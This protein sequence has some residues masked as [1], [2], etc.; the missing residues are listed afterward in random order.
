MYVLMDMVDP[1]AAWASRFTLPGRVDVVTVQVSCQCDSVV[2]YQL[3]YQKRDEGCDYDLE[4][5]TFRT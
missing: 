5:S 4:T 2:L 3:N 1:S